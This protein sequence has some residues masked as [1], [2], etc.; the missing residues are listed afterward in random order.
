MDPASP[1]VPG[2]ATPWAVRYASYL[3][4]AGVELQAVAPVFWRWPARVARQAEP[5]TWSSTVK[6]PAAHFRQCR[7]D[8][9][10]PRW[11]RAE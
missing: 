3:M 10:V 7:A 1:P 8:G 11:L 6:G 4:W 2:L 5:D 9:T